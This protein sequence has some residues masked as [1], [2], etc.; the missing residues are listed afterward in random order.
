MEI[1]FSHKPCKNKKEKF[2]GIYLPLAIIILITFANITLF[3]IFYFKN[4][5][6]HNKIN[7]I[8]TEIKST[9]IKT[10]IIVKKLQKVKY[11]EFIKEYAFL[12]SILAKKNLKWTTLFNRLEELLPYSVRI[13]VI[14]P[15]TKKGITKLHITAEALDKDSQLKFIENLLNSKDFYKPSIENESV[16][17]TTHNIKFS[18]TVVYKGES[19]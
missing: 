11:K 18:M 12:T 8:N 16:D 3:G 5:D 15:T 17:S 1:N 13:I 10:N 9:N 6:I 7:N 4:T 19:K 2:L 14:S